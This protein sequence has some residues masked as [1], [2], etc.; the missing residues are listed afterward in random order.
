MS[1]ERY[2]DGLIEHALGAP[3]SADVAA[4]LSSCA[5][6]RAR[7][8]AERRLAADIDGLLTTALRVEPRDGFEERVRRHVRAADRRAPRAVR[9]IGVGAGLAAV[10]AI[11]LLVRPR[12]DDR[13]APVATS[14]PA[15]VRATEAPRALPTSIPVAATSTAGLRPA[16]PVR[17]A[18]TRATV[19]HDVLVAPDELE[20]VERL[21]QYL[22][23]RPSTASWTHDA[24]ARL[25]FDRAAYELPPFTEDPSTGLPQLEVADVPRY[26]AEPVTSLTTGGGV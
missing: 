17:R 2:E 10:L 9:W 11:A 22:R 4:H 20:A 3:P 24:E 16:T 5:A 8:D 1:C 18:A 15:A 12:S 14:T 26:E 21:R 19:A 23:A 13:G 25:E 6:C 7:L